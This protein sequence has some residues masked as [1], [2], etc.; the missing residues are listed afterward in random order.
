MVGSGHA[1][2]ARNLGSVS[3]TNVSDVTSSAVVS[4]RRQPNS[5][6]FSR[7]QLL[8]KLRTLLLRLKNLRCT[9]GDF[10]GLLVFDD[11]AD[12]C[13]SKFMHCEQ[14]VETHL[15]HD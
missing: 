6:D 12:A 9:K 3:W 2:K 11:E 5:R 15:E 13:H 4:Q 7:C 14:P 1:P 10:I 8:Q